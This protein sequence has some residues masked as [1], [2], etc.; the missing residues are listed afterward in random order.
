MDRAPALLGRRGFL[1]AGV[2]ACGAAWLPTWTAAGTLR[3]EPAP[4]AAAH[5]CWQAARAAVHAFPLSGPVK[6]YIETNGSGWCAGSASGADLDVWASMLLPLAGVVALGRP[7]RASAA[8]DEAAFWATIWHDG[9]CTV[10]L[11]RN[12]ALRRADTLT[13]RSQAG[14]LTIAA[15]GGRWMPGDGSGAQTIPL[16]EG[17]RSLGPGPSDAAREHALMA[18]RMVRDCVTRGHRRS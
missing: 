5:P 11:V 16:P 18:A 17:A 3:P 14:V 8:G 4:C 1:A 9:D 15:S 10:Q 2:T 6:V 7:L 13:L 12:Q